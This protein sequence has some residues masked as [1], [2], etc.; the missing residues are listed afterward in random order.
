VIPSKNKAEYFRRQLIN[1]GQY[2]PLINTA[3]IMKSASSLSAVADALY[4]ALMEVETTG[5]FATGGKLEGCPLPG[6]VVEGVSAIALPLQPDQAKSL[7]E[8]S[9]QAP[10]G[11]GAD[12]VVDTAVR[13]CRQVEPAKIRLGAAWNAYIQKRTAAYVDQLGVSNDNVE[14]RLY[15][16]VLYEEGGFFKS[17]KDTEKEPGMFGSLVVQLP[18]K[19]D[20]GTLAVCHHGEEILF[21]FSND[22]NADFYGAAFY[23]DCEHEL[24]PV[25]N[26]TRLCLLYNLVRVGGNGP[27][28][29][30]LLD[31]DALCDTLLQI[32]TQWENDT[33][34]PEKLCLALDH[35]YTTKNL[36][37]R[38]LKGLDKVRV[39][40]ALVEKHMS[41]D[42]VYEHSRYGYSNYGDDYASD[43]SEDSGSG[44]GWRE[45]GGKHHEMED[46]HETSTTVMKWINVQDVEVTMKGLDID[47]DEEMLNNEEELFGEDEEPDKEEYE[48]YMGN[49][50]PTVEYWYHRAVLVIW[51]HS[52]SMEIACNASFEAAVHLAKQCATSKSSDALSTLQEVVEYAMRNA[53]RACAQ[54][55]PLL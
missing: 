45:G 17:H 52:K 15:K 32:A 43:G 6:L 37:F 3:A 47:L 26:G 46:C 2:P 8:H 34:A 28:P 40:L 27:L 23:T 30:S 19:H 42:A 48:G 10:F 55:A 53:D 44:C 54:L 9:I 18:A 1:T 51:P 7:A 21:D 22:S 35:E 4:E 16:L 39:D 50:G 36:G 25:E 33:D 14:A 38:N 49:Y 24:H 13:L 12:T 20:A 31:H 11:R 5:A 41:G 29:S